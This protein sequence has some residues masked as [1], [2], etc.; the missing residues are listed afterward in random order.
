M[1]IYLL[2]FITALTGYCIHK[3]F[4]FLLFSPSDK[5]TF[6]G[7]PIQ[8]FIP[9]RQK[10]L[11]ADIA[12]TL[13]AGF[14]DLNKITAPVKDPKQLE[15]VKPLIAE[16]I[17]HFLNHKLKEK[18]PVISMFIGSGTVDK[19]K[20]GLM[21]EIDIL[22][23]KLIGQYIDNLVSKTDVKGLITVKISELSTQQIKNALL[24]AIA[25]PLSILGTLSGFAAG[26]VAIAA[27]LLATL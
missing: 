12:Q 23:P 15:A 19:V 18:L 21:E 8:G 6:I 27:V 26:L 11:A 16:Q 1:I 17:D 7:I 5:T 25:K 3:L 9:A 13:T 22:L 14:L 20:E 4:L 10:Q 24:P 2:P